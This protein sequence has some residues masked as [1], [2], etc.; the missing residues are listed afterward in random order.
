V[1]QVVVQNASFIKEKIDK[2]EEHEKSN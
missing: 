1:K 2:Q